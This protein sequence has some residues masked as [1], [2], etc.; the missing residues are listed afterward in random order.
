[1]PIAKRKP[2]QVTQYRV[3]ASHRERDVGTTRVM[4]TAMT[5]KRR[6]TRYANRMARRRSG[7]SVYPRQV[8][9]YQVPPGQTRGSLVHQVHFNSKLNR[10]IS[11]EL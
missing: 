6:A 7:R 4:M 1:M 3:F 5:T 11:E 9:V 10:L 8:S 2:K